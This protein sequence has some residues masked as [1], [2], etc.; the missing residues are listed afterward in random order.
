MMRLMICR[1]NTVDGFQGQEKDIII[2]SC[3][4]SGPNLKA[5]GFLKDPRRMNVALTRAKSSLFIIGNGPTLERGDERWK[6]IVGDARERGFFIDYT[7][8]TF[9]PEAEPIPKKVKKPSSPMAKASIHSSASKAIDAARLASIQNAAI[10]TVKPNF[11]EAVKQKRKFDAEMSP[12]NEKKLRVDDRHVPM[13]SPKIPHDQTGRPGTNGANGSSVKPSMSVTRPGPPPAPKS[14]VPPP[15]PAEEVLFIK[16]KK[17][18]Y[19]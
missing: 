12:V 13:A 15:R 6:G 3:V 10:D 11:T 9:A 7:P 1:F 14:I 19:P 5:I 4:R 8:S 16:K 2:L 18:R 17:A